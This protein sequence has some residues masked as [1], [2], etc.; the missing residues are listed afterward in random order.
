MSDDE[1]SNEI[2]RVDDV[3]SEDGI[4][5]EQQSVGSETRVRYWMTVCNIWE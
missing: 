1:A 5:E 3:S 4:G 2:T